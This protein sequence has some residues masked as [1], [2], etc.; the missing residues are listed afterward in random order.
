MRPAVPLL[1]NKTVPPQGDV[2]NGMFVPG[3]TAVGWNLLTM[4][5]SPEHWG[6][7]ADVFR[8]ERFMEADEKTRASME[9]LVD[10]AF[11]YGK[12]GYAGKPLAFMELN[13]VFFEVKWPYAPASSGPTWGSPSLRCVAAD[14]VLPQ[15]LFRHFDFQLVNPAE[16]WISEFYTV[17]METDFLVEIT[18][19]SLSSTSTPQ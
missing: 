16:P 17:F 4:M 3:G 11:G 6:P 5:R 12:F 7:D 1:F 9:R 19:S 8:P 13:K 18:E 10:L 14:D 15:Q 2:I